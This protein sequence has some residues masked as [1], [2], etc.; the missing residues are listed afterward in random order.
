MHIGMIGV[1][2]VIERQELTRRCMTLGD[3]IEIYQGGFIVLFAG[4]RER[5]CRLLYFAIQKWSTYSRQ[6]PATSKADLMALL[7]N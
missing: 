7:L 1:R 4:V 5:C 2:K 3:G 6:R